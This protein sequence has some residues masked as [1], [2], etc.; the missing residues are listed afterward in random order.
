MRLTLRLDPAVVEGGVLAL[1]EWMHGDSLMNTTDL[2]QMT[3]ALSVT[4]VISIVCHCH[5]Q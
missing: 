5:F 3:L 1:P 4:T 2:F